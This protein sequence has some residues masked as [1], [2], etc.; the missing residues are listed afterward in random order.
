MSLIFAFLLFESNKNKDGRDSIREN[1]GS[2]RCELS[3]LSD[4]WLPL[5]SPLLSF[6]EEITNH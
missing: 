5:L 6:H 3:V 4:D 2:V 1:L